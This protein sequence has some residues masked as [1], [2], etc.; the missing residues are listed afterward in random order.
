MRNRLLIA[1]AIIGI[2]GG[3]ISAHFYGLKNKPQ[4]PAFNPASNPYAKG[5]YANGS[6]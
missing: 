1:I 5:I 6:I 2:L 3:F 4:P